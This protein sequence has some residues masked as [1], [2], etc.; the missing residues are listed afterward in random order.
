MK[1][2]SPSKKT[3]FRFFELKSDPM[4]GLSYLQNDLSNCVNHADKAE[5]KEFQLL[6]G[7]I[8]NQVQKIGF[9]N[10]ISLTLIYLG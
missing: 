2:F 6:A 7:Q 4:V 10:H 9:I 1:D 3:L 8:F 5:E